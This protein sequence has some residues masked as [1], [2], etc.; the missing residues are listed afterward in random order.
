MYIYLFKYLNIIFK[1]ISTL[2]C[3]KNI[4]LMAT[5]HPSRVKQQKIR[6]IMLINI[7]NADVTSAP[8]VGMGST[9]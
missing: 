7:G 2:L 5:E 6:L 9:V 3:D 8:D 1:N 4:S